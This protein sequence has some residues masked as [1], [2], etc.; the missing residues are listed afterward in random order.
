MRL[1]RTELMLK[2]AFLWAERSTCNR[3]HVGCVFARDSRIICTGYNG[4]P[5]G[6]PHCGEE[7]NDSTPCL[8]SGH[9]ESNAISWAARNGIKL[10]GSTLYSTD[11]PCYNCAMLLINVGVEGVIFSRAYR[12]TDGVKLL[13]DAFISVIHY[14]EVGQ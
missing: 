6:M 10:E 9:A 8:R 7:C 5:A 11:S 14:E 3:L 13:R 1:D 12:I 4:S 2:T